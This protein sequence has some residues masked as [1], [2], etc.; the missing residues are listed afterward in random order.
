MFKHSL[1]TSPSASA[2][3]ALPDRRR[4]LTSFGAALLA[5][6][7]LLGA[8]PPTARAQLDPTGGKAGTYDIVQDSRVVGTIFVPAWHDPNAGL[9]DNARYVEHWVLFPGYV[10][11]SPANG[12]AITIRPAAEQRYASEADFFARV[13]WGA[14][15]RYVR[16]DATDGTTLPGR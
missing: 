3:L 13:P 15:S 1:H 12:K 4:A 14:G 6:T 16:V 10:Y 11:P 9:P 8:S 5:A 7:A 2:P